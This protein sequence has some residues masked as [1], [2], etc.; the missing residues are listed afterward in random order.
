ML[1]KN[2][3]N[4][5]FVSYIKERLNKQYSSTY[6]RLWDV[7]LVIFCYN[8]QIIV[9]LKPKFELYEEKYC[10]HLI[11]KNATSGMSFGMRIK[12]EHPTLN[13]RL[14]LLSATV[15]HAWHGRRGGGHSHCTMLQ[16]VP[17]L[18]P[19]FSVLFLAPRTHLFKPFSSSRDHTSIFWKK[20]CIFKPTFANFG[21]SSWDAISKKLF[22][23][24]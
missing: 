20:I 2:W 3:H 1:V 23:R 13:Y 18:R 4:Q 19:P 7:C 14:W 6:Y 16:D 17:L 10:F 15:I 8:F 24:P 21:Y 5:V 12:K 11:Q 9:I 22:W